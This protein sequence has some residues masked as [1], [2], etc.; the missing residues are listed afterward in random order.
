MALDNC[1]R[2]T[3][4]HEALIYRRKKSSTTTTSIIIIFSS[5]HRPVTPFYRPRSLLLLLLLLV[6]VFLPTI[7]PIRRIFGKDTIDRYT[8]PAE[9]VRRD[10]LRPFS[11]S[12]MMNMPRALVTGSR[13]NDRC[14]DHGVSEHQTRNV[15]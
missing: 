15:R 13:L 1:A 10:S 2:R 14:D 9:R 5:H 6:T 11:S 12:I 3:S 4:P 7:G 8:G